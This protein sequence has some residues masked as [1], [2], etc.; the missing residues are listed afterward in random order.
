MKEEAAMLNLLWAVAVILFVAWVFGLALHYTAGGL[1][2]V[3]LMMAIFSG[4]VR[5]ILGREVV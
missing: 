2:H 3:L 1:I 5:V 4:L